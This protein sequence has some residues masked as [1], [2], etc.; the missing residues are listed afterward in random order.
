[1]DFLTSTHGEEGTW[2]S[3]TY[4]RNENKEMEGDIMLSIFKGW[5]TSIVENSIPVSF[6]YS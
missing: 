6:A 4:L 2:C 5:S 3:G 1:M